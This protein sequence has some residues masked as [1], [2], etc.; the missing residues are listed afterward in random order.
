MSQIS[1]PSLSHS[2]LAPGDSVFF[3]LN[4]NCVCKRRHQLSL[5][6]KA[7]PFCRLF[8]YANWNSFAILIQLAPL[9]TPDLH[10]VATPHPQQSEND[11]PSFY[12]ESLVRHSN[13]VRKRS[14]KSIRKLDLVAN[15]RHQKRDTPSAI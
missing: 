9:L 15:L 1:P 4:I 2:P 12:R 5:W 10:V 8:V 13:V 11:S 6:N 14:Y 7:N 3:S